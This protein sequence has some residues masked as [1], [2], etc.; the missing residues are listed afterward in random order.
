VAF[1]SY[2]YLGSAVIAAVVAWS[3]LPLWRHCCQRTGLVDA[4]GPRKIHTKPVPLAG[5]FAILSGIL[6]PPVGLLL[7]LHFSLLNSS[8]TEHITQSFTAIPSEW[9]TIIGGALAITFLGWIDDR[10]DLRPAAKFLGQTIVAIM[11]AYAGIRI[12]LFVPNTLFSYVITILWILTVTNAL[13]FM[14]NMNGLCTGLGSIAALFLGLE[15]ARQSQNLVAV[16]SFLV[17]GASLG[18]LLWNFPRAS[19]FLGDAGSHLIGFLLAVLTILPDFHSSAHPHP[20]AVVTPLFLLAVPLADL[21]WVAIARTIRGRPFYLGDTNHL[22]HRLVRRGLT[23][24]QAVVVIWIAATTLS[25]LALLL[26]SA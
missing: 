24:A 7:A 9:V 12:T 10:H 17:M 18:F 25:C 21:A 4:P 1:N 2:L 26:T 3:S 23:P 20:W 19:A 5:G 22:S 11:V 13:N 8:A 16:F 14:D 6:L 15:A